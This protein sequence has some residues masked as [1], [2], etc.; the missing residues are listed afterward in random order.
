MQ[1]NITQYFW[2]GCDFVVPALFLIIAT[3]LFQHSNFDIAFQS[4]FYQP[5]N[6]W[7]L[8]ERFP[9]KMLYHFGVV[10]ALL[11]TIAAVWILIESFHITKWV[12]WRKMTIF[13]ISLMLLAPGLIINTALKQQWGRPRPR[14]V[15]EFGG[16]ERFEPVLTIDHSSTGESF[17]C[18]H[19]SVGFVLIAP[20]YLLRR[21]NLLLAVSC[22]SFGMLY[23]SMIGLARIIQGGHFLS[24][25]IWAACIVWLTAST[26]FYLLRLHTSIWYRSYQHKVQRHSLLFRSM[27]ITLL[28]IIIAIILVATPYNRIKRYRQAKHISIKLPIR[29]QA[30]LTE[31]NMTISS[32]SL[33]MYSTQLQG[34]G[35]P[36]SKLQN[37]WK[38]SL[39]DLV[40]SITLTQQ[41]KGFLSELTQNSTLT[42]NPNNRASYRIS[43]PQG[44]ITMRVPL[45]QT[46]IA[47]DIYMQSGEL[48][49]LPD[50][51][52]SYTIERISDHRVVKRTSNS[53]HN[54]PLR[55]RIYSDKALYRLQSK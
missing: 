28:L 46:P 53:I 41:K 16:M 6:G 1:K 51:L 54:T 52:A 4:K 47:W 55:I 21:K 32:D 26:L 9:W 10:P 48:T 15:V 11:F 39:A 38:E 37:R 5:T 20:Y 45:V 17:P 34:F 18:G 14:Q 23:G 42:W 19:A 29:F 31:A 13:F 30:N 22:F 24:D 40:L 12:P 2:I 25:V 3:W 43:L 50:S 33:L 7:F 36:G 27:A 8:A 35:F 44:N 49:F